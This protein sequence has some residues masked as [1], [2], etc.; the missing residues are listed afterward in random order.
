[1]GNSKIKI[2]KDGP[3]IVTGNVPLIEKFI[4]PKGNG[5][6]Y[7]DGRSFPQQET[8]ALCRCGKSK[9][10]PFCDGSHEVAGFH[11]K[12]TASKLSYEARAG[13]LEGEALDLRDDNRCAYARCCHRE[14]GSVWKLTEESGDVENRREAIK[15]ACECPSGRLVAMDKEGNA[16]EEVYEPSIDILQDPECQASGGIFVKGNI[17]IE[18]ID[19]ELYE[20]RNRVVLC[21]CGKS[22]NMP[23][24]DATHVQLM[25]K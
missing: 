21:R 20:I 17:P 22:D 25:C 24:C 16:I 2:L 9:N 10:S 19:G 1:M 6:E 7:E 15:A 4:V 8:Y 11:G 3:Y 5:Y 18:S 13:I 23:F 12:E 14:N